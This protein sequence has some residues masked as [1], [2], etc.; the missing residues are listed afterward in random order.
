MWD[1][2]LW[3]L[4]QVLNRRGEY[5]L[6]VSRVRYITDYQARGDILEH[7][8]RQSQNYS[9]IS[10]SNVLIS[11]LRWSHYWSLLSINRS[12]IIYYELIIQSDWYSIANEVMN[13]IHPRHVTPLYAHTNPHRIYVHIALN[14]SC[15]YRLV[16]YIGC[17]LVTPSE[18]ASQTED[19]F[20]SVNFAPQQ[21]L[22][23]Y[24]CP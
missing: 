22:Q 5:S 23:I 15:I 7:Y 16:A 17:Q 13:S 1:T 21:S 20:W 18:S 6:W 9:S 10:L 24:T 14:R 2:A 12:Q 19:C 8:S 3:T 11:G 4:L